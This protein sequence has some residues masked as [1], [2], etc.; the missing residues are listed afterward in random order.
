MLPPPSTKRPKLLPEVPRFQTPLR[1][2]FKLNQAAL[3]EHEGD[4]AWERSSIASGVAHSG[5]SH[6][7]DA[8]FSLSEF[9]PKP[10]HQYQISEDVIM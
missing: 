2:E 7:P 10:K 1:D 8:R 9:L 6:A 5:S 4:S 3:L